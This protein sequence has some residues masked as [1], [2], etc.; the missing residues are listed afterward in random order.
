MRGL[1]VC[2]LALLFLGACTSDKEK[3][4]Q[5]FKTGRQKIYSH[6]LTGAIEDLSQAIQY[7]REL[8]QAWYYR[9]NAYYNLRDVDA[10]KADYDTCIMINPSFAEAY[11]NRGS[12]LFEKGDRDAACSDWRKAKELG[13]ENMSSR[14]MNCLE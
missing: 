6:D 9:G 2:F 3:A 12:I 4:D 11:A 7:N 1:A 5:F 10:A 13:K 14:L 8:D